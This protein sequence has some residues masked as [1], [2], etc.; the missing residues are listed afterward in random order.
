MRGERV[1]L[2][3]MLAL[4]LGQGVGEALAKSEAR[5]TVTSMSAGAD[6]AQLQSAAWMWMQATAASPQFLT[7]VAAGVVL[8]GFLYYLWGWLQRLLH[9]VNFAIKHRLAVVGIALIAYFG[10]ARYLMA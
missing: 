5:H 10:F 1:F 6:V 2:A 4:S 8:C 3:V 9:L 7:G